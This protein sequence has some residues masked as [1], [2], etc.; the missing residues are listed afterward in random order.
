M[1]ARVAGF[2]SD[3]LVNYQTSC[4]IFPMKTRD[5]RFV[6][7]NQKKSRSV[8]SEIES[9][10]SE[11][12]YYI[13]SVAFI[14]SGGLAPLKLILKELDEKGICGKILTTDYQ[15]MTE[16]AALK[17]LLRLKNLEVRLFKS[18][19]EKRAGF[20]T[21]GYLFS[22]EKN[23]SLL[24][25][26]SNLTQY[27][28]KTNMEWNLEYSAEKADPLFDEVLNEFNYLWESSVDVS[29][30]L[31]TYKRIYE[32]NRK[33]LKRQKLDNE[34]PIKPNIM[35]LEFIENV[36]R[37]IEGGSDRALLISATGTGKTYASAFFARDFS[38]KRMLFIAHRSRLLSQAV[39]V[40][41]KVFA[42]HDTGILSGESK[43]YSSRLLF[44]TVQTLS[45][46]EVLE[47]FS[48]SDFDLIIIDEVHKAAASSYQKVLDYFSPSFFLG[49]TATPERTDDSSSIFSLF[50]YN[51]AL[52]IRLQDAL[53][54]NLLCPFHYY[55]IDD[56]KINGETYKQR[57]FARLTSP[58]R[59]K[60]VLSQAEYYGCS[61]PRVKGLIFVSDIREGKILE[62]TLNEDYAL[63]VKFLCF[64]NSQKEKDDAIDALEADSGNML[65]Y[66]ITVDIFN[67]GVDIPSVNQVIF[68]RPTKSS[69]I[70]IQQLGRG[71]R[72]MEG[73][74]YVVILDFIANVDNNYMI[75][76]ALNGS[77]SFSKDESR[78]YMMEANSIIPGLS[79]VHF[80]RRAKEEIFRAINTHNLSKRECRDAYRKLKEKIGR[81]PSLFDFKKYGT[82]DPMVIITRTSAS[83]SLLFS[84][85]SEFICY[86]DDECGLSF[87]PVEEKYFSFIS[88]WVLSSKRK[89]EAEFLRSLIEKKS[90]KKEDTRLFA[91]LYSLFS[92][93]Y[94]SEREREKYDGI[95]FF[96]DDGMYIS[97]SPLFASLLESNVFR[98]E[99]EMYIRF[100]IARVS[101]RYDESSTFTL[102]KKYTRKDVSRLLNW[103][104]DSTS[105]IYGY[106]VKDG[107]CPIFVTLEKKN[108]SCQTSYEDA[109]Y[110]DE[111]FRWFSRSNLTLESSEIK[112]INS[113]R[114]N[115]LKMYLFA[116]KNDDSDSAEHY[117]LGP[118]V[119]ES[120]KEEKMRNDK[121]DEIPVIEY[122]LRMKERVK[123]EL[124]DYLTHEEY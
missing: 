70:F 42:E 116:K 46:K 68:L 121:G 49:M 77:S 57:D 124:F 118:V 23:M 34:K 87:L 98:N 103:E 92:L 106:T 100:S 17:D 7:N 115:G 89:A 117:Y 45:Q 108:V 69:I 22:S 55:A 94:L 71:L 13:F 32:E 16:P 5:V 110:S 109:F 30:Y 80:S 11:C 2:F 113:F 63:K 114:K 15:L 85:W 20:H 35:Q 60:H 43:C 61:G 33:A 18:N 10:L 73:K 82:I 47:K 97:I 3:D 66:I 51:I 14:T 9:R 50:K 74:E 81:I 54:Q 56:L 102:Y 84:S 25:G 4:Y 123:G 99:I 107:S 53:E 101:E 86:S 78:R 26:S 93:S 83:K 122:R 8:L 48:P 111:A 31:D 90:V 119:P 12:K 112:A 72:K 24:I 91:S 29:S 64:E 44:S 37:I 79:S 58:E 38:P 41:E 120:W 96:T 6:L 104:K 65:D 39:N 62:Q 1:P 75:P 40:F 76:L 88:S 52:E 21:K 28:L 59:I 36:K 67:E 105:T 19:E 27:A 95:S